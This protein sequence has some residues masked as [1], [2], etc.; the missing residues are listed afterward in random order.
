MRFPLFSD[1]NIFDNANS[2]ESQDAR[3]LSVGRLTLTAAVT[4]LLIGA[5]L[6]AST[7]IAQAA[8]VPGS[9]Q[10]KA[11][12]MKTTTKTKKS[13]RK[14]HR[15]PMPRPSRT[16]ATSPAPSPTRTTTPSQST[17][18][19]PSPTG[20]TTPGGAN[21]S[22]ERL[23]IG[24]LPGWK[25]VFTDDFTTQVPL[26]RFP[27]AVSSKWGAY[28]DGWKDTSGNG[29]YYPSKVISV[30]NGMM[31]MHLHTENGIHMVAAPVPKIPGAKGSSG[32]M[33]YGRYAARFRADDLPGYKTAWL[34]WPDSDRWSEGEIDF[35]EGN[36][37]RG[38]KIWAFTHYKGDPEEQDAFKTNATYD[39]WHTAVIEWTP[40]SV[41]YIL[42]GVTIGKTTN[43]S[44][45]PDNPMYWVLQTET[46]VGSGAVEPKDSVRGNVQVDWVAVWARS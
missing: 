3:R 10:A 5:S 9:S 39:S 16:R 29:Q 25:Q 37:A 40:E 32:G 23:P 11:E 42:D 28:D 6:M 34:L 12:T 19:T 24:D 21:P 13:T 45:I 27:D 22:G 35:P 46:E 4:S 15:K 20:T 33:T 2:Q 26:G 31:N 8:T 30:D 18:P 7:G 1:K 14:S 38:E 44:I 41:T 36:L 17:S 43:R